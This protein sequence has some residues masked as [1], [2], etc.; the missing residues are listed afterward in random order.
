MKEPK[1]HE[2]VD[3]PDWA[4]DE[5]TVCAA[6]N[7]SWPCKT[8][9]KWLASPEYRLGEIEKKL[10][11]N[12]KREDKARQELRET[13]EKLRRLELLVRGGVMLHLYENGARISES[14]QVDSEFLDF[15]YGGETISMGGGRREY[16]VEYT[17]KNSRYVNGRLEESWS[18]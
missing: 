7:E 1:G 6:D 15:S 11:E 16:T 2:E 3:L 17:G 10:A 8:W 14:V 5:P 4:W 12:Q 13:K 9:R 18:P